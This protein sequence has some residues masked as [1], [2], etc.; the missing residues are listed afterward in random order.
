MSSVGD[1]LEELRPPSF[2]IAYRMLGSV[3]EAEDVV[4]EALLPGSSTWSFTLA[5]CRARNRSTSTSAVGEGSESRP[6]LAHTART[7]RGVSSRAVRTEEVAPGIRGP[8]Q[9]RGLAERNNMPMSATGPR[10]ASFCGL[11]IELTRW[12]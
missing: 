9:S 2:A 7:V 6:R 12:I 10:C 3:A 8:S 4:Q 1:L 5:T 11:T